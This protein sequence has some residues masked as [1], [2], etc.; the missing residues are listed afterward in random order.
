M[1]SFIVNPGVLFGIGVINFIT[2]VSF[3]INLCSH[4]RNKRYIC[5]MHLLFWV[6]FNVTIFL[7]GILP[8]LNKLIEEFNKINVIY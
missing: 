2:I 3:I 8:E 4:Y 1:E 7:V 6:V 5:Y